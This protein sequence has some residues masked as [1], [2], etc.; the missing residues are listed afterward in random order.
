MKIGDFMHHLLSADSSVVHSPY[1]FAVGILLL[2][3]PVATLS[4]GIILYTVF[5]RGRPLDGP[6]VQLLLGLLG[7]ATGGFGVSMF[8]RTTTFMSQQITGPVPGPTSGS[9]QVGP[10]TQDPDAP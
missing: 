5:W 9:H 7:A 10:A 8:S 1:A 2:A 3:T 4:M 6:M